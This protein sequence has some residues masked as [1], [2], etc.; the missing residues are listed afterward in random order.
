MNQSGAYSVSKRSQSKY[1]NQYYL[2]SESERKNGAAVTPKSI[3]M[4][5]NDPTNS[6]E[7][8]PFLD[9]PPTEPVRLTP[10]WEDNNLTDDELNFKS[11]TMEQANLELNPPK[12]RYMLVYLTLVLHG[13]GILMPWNM[14]ITA[15]SYFV[16]YKLSESYT[17]VKSDYVTFFQSY[18]AF[19][20]QIPNLAFNWINIFIQIGGN[21]TTRIVWSIFIEVVIF[22]FTVI[23]AMTDSS[24]WSGVF[25]WITMV[26]VVIL[27]VANGIYQNTV[28]GMGAKLPFK[29]TGAII[30]GSNIS[31]AFT[32]II[33][34]LSIAIAPNKRTAAIYY[35]ITALFV[36]LACFDTYFALPLNR[37]YR[38]NEYIKQKSDQIIRRENAGLKPKVPYWQ[39]FKKAF[40]QLF[41]VFFVFFVTL[42]IF[43]S[44]HSDIQKSDPDFFIPDKYYVS[45]MCFM[46]FN[47]TAM[48]G[49]LVTNWIRWPSAKYLV[50]PVVLRALFIPFFLFCNYRP[51][52]IARVLPVLFANDWGYWVA[53][54]LMGFSSG[55][56]SSLAMM[57]TSGTVEPV[58]ASIAGMFGGA[59]LITGVCSGILFACIFPWIVRTINI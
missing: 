17:G 37:F 38:Y 45:I 29:Y 59:I 54:V 51:V 7:R 57:Y 44:M 12:D 41:N 56:C 6:I 27:N 40:P 22:V 28:Y 26:T 23:L 53:A 10:A 25:F 43:P 18:L 55:Y 1:D 14:F 39:V 9:R 3:T 33:N 8:Q 32:A 35:F 46:T 19:A 42:S 47:I 13:I 15:K 24:D 58:H 52:G 16:D 30:L 49:S 36:L 31:G 2:L 5:G 21:L 48:L 11:L 50:I 4:K 34:L 20:S